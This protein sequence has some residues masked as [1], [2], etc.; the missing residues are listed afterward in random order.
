M[1]ETRAIAIWGLLALAP[2]AAMAEPTGAEIAKRALEGDI[3]SASNARAEVELAVS[4]DGKPLRERRILS[5]I[6]RE[7]GTVRAMIEFL[8]PADVAGTRLLA[9]REGDGRSEQ[10]VYLPAFKKVKRVVGGQRSQSFMG[11]DFAYADLGG[12]DPVAVSWKRLPDEKLAGQP[13]QVVEGEPKAPEDDGYGRFVMWIHEKHGIPMRIDF[14]A[15]DRQTLTKRLTVRKLEKRSE[16]WLAT[17]A[18]MQTQKSGTET[19]MTLVALDFDT[20][21]AADELSRA[22]LER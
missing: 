6:K 7:Q 3:F 1:G 5:K 15:L 13:C 4:K 10:F 12:R 17:E 20:E 22:A 11:T 18:V 16:R 8:A 9:V 2:G 21:I 14:Y 19:K